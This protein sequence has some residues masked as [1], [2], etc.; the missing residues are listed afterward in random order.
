M[1]KKILFIGNDTGRTGAPI[2]LLEIAR[3]FKSQGWNCVFLFESDGILQ[4]DYENL[5]DVFFWNANLDKI[6][7]KYKRW[8]AKGFYKYGFNT[9]CRK[10]IIKD[11]AKRQVKVVYGNT[12][13]SG[14]LIAALDLQQTVTFQHLHE[15]E[16]M[17]KYHCGNKFTDGIAFTDYFIAINRQIEQTL[18][19]Q[20]NIEREK[21]I[22]QNIFVPYAVDIEKLSKKGSKKFVVGGAGVPTHRKGFDLFIAI[23]EAVK[24]VDAEIEFRWVGF[25]QCNTLNSHYIKAIDDK[26]LNSTIKLIPPTATPLNEFIEFDILLLTSREDP[27]PLVVLESGLLG[28]PVVCF[29]DS[30]ATHQIAEDGGGILV[31]MENIDAASNAIIQLKANQHIYARCSKRINEIVSTQYDKDKNLESI[32]Q[33]VVKTTSKLE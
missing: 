16:Q 12:G 6:A 28:K 25:D 30:G 29:V 1:D 13:I 27:N 4:A 3:Y 26:E 24:N 18:I 22:A 31:E 14:Y 10:K 8:I 23:A 7:N 20:Y 21:I 19:N 15:M 32:Y 17:L 11:I 5:G 9:I 2:I 33:I